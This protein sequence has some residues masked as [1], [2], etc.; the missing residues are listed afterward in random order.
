MSEREYLSVFR[1][2]PEVMTVIEV[3]KLLRIGKNKAYDLVGSGRL[4]SIK[5]GGKIIVPKL[6]LITFLCSE[7]N[8]QFYPASSR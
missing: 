2:Q 6:C 1:N 8:Y 5:I 4:S 7:N 3:S